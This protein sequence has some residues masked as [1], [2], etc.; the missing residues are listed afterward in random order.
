MNWREKQAKHEQWIEAGR[1]IAQTLKKYPNIEERPFRIWHAYTLETMYKD[2][3]KLPSCNC[4]DEGDR[5]IGIVPLR[6]S[7][8][9]FQLKT[10]CWLCWEKA[11][12]QLKWDDIGE[13]DVIKIFSHYFA[14]NEPDYR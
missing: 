8:D 9:V 12:Q 3:P 2:T 14:D 1:D 7:N 11:S 5:M 6:K 13:S 4:R 10:I